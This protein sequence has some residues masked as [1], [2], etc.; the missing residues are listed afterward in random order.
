MSF[1]LLNETNPPVWC[2]AL[3]YLWFHPFKKC[4]DACEYPI[5]LDHW[6]HDRVGSAFDITN[7]EI[8]IILRQ[9]SISG[10][11]VE[12]SLHQINEAA[13][14]GQQDQHADDNGHDDPD[15]GD[16]RPAGDIP[17]IAKGGD[18][19]QHDQRDEEQRRQ[20]H[21]QDDLPGKLS[22]MFEIGFVHVLWDF[23]FHLFF[24]RT[25]SSG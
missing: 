7:R 16:R 6:L 15:R 20:H 21:G 9:A 19:D 4:F 25:A 1:R 24:I 17:I 10:C 14:Q 5:D 22:A 18:I 13:K 12:Q 23:G 11:D 2:D 3:L 8:N